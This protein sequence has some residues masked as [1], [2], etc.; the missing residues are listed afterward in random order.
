M[1]IHS[2]LPRLFAI[3]AAIST[4]A[5]LSLPSPAQAQESEDPTRLDRTLDKYWGEKRELRT[6]QKRLFLKDTRWAFS[7]FGGVV[8]ND[9]F[10]VFFPV[11]GRV[12]YWFSE[13]LGLELSGAYN[14]RNETD[15][16]TF[17]REEIEGDGQDARIFLTQTI[18]WYSSLDLL[19]SPFHG[20]FGAFATKLVHFDF[21]F[22]IGAGVHG[23]T[24]DP[25]GAD[26]GEESVFRIAGN[27]GLGVMMYAL[28]WLAVRVDYRH[29]FFEFA[30]GGGLSYP[31]E[32]TAGLT[33]F[34]PAPE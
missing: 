11:G 12:D 27:V 28:D 30:D 31:A 15:L 32:I 9:E 22:A 10:Q 18:D 7:V 25:P 5:A 19:W 6:I 24:K 33:F 16:R 13:D 14:F 23:L 3:I 17:L 1:C 21:Y 29:F 26:A 20:K 2:R 8:P 34:T 4:F